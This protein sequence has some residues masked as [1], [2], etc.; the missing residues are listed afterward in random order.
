LKLAN[1]SQIAA[2]ALESLFYLSQNVTD[3]EEIGY[4]S[5]IAPT[6]VKTLRGYIR[7]ALRDAGID[8]R[9][10]LLNMIV[11]AYPP[12]WVERGS[13]GEESD[14]DLTTT[15]EDEG[16]YDAEAR[17]VQ[18]FTQAVSRDLEWRLRK[19]GQKWR[20]SLTGDKAGK[21]TA[22]PTTSTHQP[23]TLYAF[24]VIQHVV[25]LASLDPSKEDS[26]PVVVLEQIPLND[27]SQWLWNALSLALPVNLAR[28]VLCGLWNTGNIV[29]LQPSTK[30]DPDL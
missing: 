2:K 25:L 6:V 11:R 10:S 4:E 3:Y 30:D 26:T 21:K 24:A 16:P 20:D 1:C 9:K 13:A 29:A 8:E 5:K 19:L 12:D 7:W 23:P 14:T 27:R 28:D 17:R 15:D 22:T 18:R